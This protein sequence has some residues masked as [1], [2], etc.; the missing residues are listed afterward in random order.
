MFLVFGSCLR[1]LFAVCQTR[2]CPS[3]MSM[4]ATRTLLTVRTSCPVRKSHRW[5]SQPS[6]NGRA[7]GN[8][9]IS[10]LVLFTGASPTNTL[11][12][13]RLM[14]V[15]VICSKTFF[16]YQQVILVP[17]VEQVWMNEEGKLLEEVHDEP[18]DL[19]VTGVASRG[20]LDL[21]VGA[22]TGLTRHMVDI[23]TDH[24]GIYANAFMI[25][26]EMEIG[27]CQEV[28]ELDA[29]TPRLSNMTKSFNRPLKEDLVAARISRVGKKKTPNGAD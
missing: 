29:R 16:N 24:P 28:F 21:L 22:W 25:L 2:Y 23:H 7:L 5:E 12:L 14:N 11:R 8:L 26:T 17:A 3:N 1:Q 20:D 6:I 27:W 13:L 15:Q 9:L 10:A 19:A 4:R 18:L